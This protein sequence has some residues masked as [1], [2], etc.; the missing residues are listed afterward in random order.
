M[1]LDGGA[2]CV[3]QASMDTVLECVHAAPSSGALLLQ[4]RERYLQHG[5]FAPGRSGGSSSGYR[6]PPSWHRLSAQFVQS[7]TS[8]QSAPSMPSVQFVPSVLSVPS[9]PGVQAVPSV[10]DGVSPARVA[11]APPEPSWPSYVRSHQPG[12]AAAFGSVAALLACV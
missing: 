11:L 7:V 5:A 3:S 4:A 6:R 9:V 12:L 1:V 8:V 2:H 10:C